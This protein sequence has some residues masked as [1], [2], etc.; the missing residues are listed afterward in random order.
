MP[1]NDHHIDDDDD[2]EGDGAPVQTVVTLD[3]ARQL[4]HSA[5]ANLTSAPCR[6]LQLPGTVELA[7]S[8]GYCPSSSSSA[9]T[10]SQHPSLAGNRP[11]MPMTVEHFCQR[12]LGINRP[13]L[14]TKTETKS[15]HLIVVKLKLSPLKQIQEN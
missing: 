8:D 9:A 10:V 6:R 12:T 15:C 14:V 3:C 11:C 4:H 13:I 5:V 2:D 7:V 1:L